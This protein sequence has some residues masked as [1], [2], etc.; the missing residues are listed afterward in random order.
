MARMNPTADPAKA[1][2][3]G[4]FVERPGGSVWSELK[5]RLEVDPVSSHVVLGG[6]GSGKT[7]ELII[8]AEKL[9]ASLQ[10]EGD[11]V[12][13]IDVS[14]QFSLDS[15]ARSGVLVALAGLGL[16]RSQPKDERS[17]EFVKAVKSLYTFAYGYQSDD[18]FSHQFPGVLDD[19]YRGNDPPNS[20][21]HAGN[22]PALLKHRNGGGKH[23]VFLFDSL[24]RLP[25]PENFVTLVQHDIAA[26]KRVGIGV[27]VVGPVRYVPGNDRGLVEL[28]DHPHFQLSVDTQNE[29]EFAFLCDVLRRRA[30]PDVLPDMCLRP[31]VLASGGV[32]RDLITLAKRAAEEAYVGGRDSVQLQDVV[33]ARDAMG[34]G[35]AIGLDDEQLVALRKV[36]ASEK[37]IVRGERELSLLETR[38]V[39]MYEG[40]RWVVHPALAPLLGL[41]PEVA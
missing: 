3:G 9:K 1:I 25:N 38:R 13:Y 4:L 29:S 31:L 33:T 28:F 14:K 41:M 12:E 11:H 24:D 26:L 17:P 22:L 19:T 8:I 39:L 15:R 6:I 23:A 7:S 16:A 36:H 20:L 32:L 27:V 30:D 35:L 40:N 37:F 2:A 21:E 5:S 10:P 18:D 34:R